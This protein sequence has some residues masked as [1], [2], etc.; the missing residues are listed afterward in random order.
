LTLFDFKSG[1]ISL[2][3]KKDLLNSNFNFIEFNFVLD[4][5]KLFVGQNPIHLFHK[6]SKSLEIKLK[7]VNLI[8]N[9][10][11]KTQPPTEETS[12]V[13]Q[14]EQEVSI[15]QNLFKFSPKEVSFKYIE[16][17]RQ[18]LILKTF[19]LLL[20]ILIQNN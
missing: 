3:T 5:E 11:S 10:S 17:Y 8:N 19:V 20:K 18:K 12:M 7:L 2:N 13:I 15:I 14:E 1:L 9:F 4:F 6:K 16:I